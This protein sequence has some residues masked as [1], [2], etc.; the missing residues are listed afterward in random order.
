MDAEKTC[1]F[2]AELIKVDAIKCRYCHSDLTA[3]PK[4][5][6]LPHPG[7]DSP[8]LL[9]ASYPAY[10]ANRLA[11]STSAA[12]WLVTAIVLFLVAGFA[13]MYGFVWSDADQSL[14]EQCF[15]MMDPR[16]CPDSV[17]RPFP[18]GSVIFACLAVFAGLASLA[19]WIVAKGVRSGHVED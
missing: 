8:G 5:A 12:S 10:A 7:A 16:P 14:P 2:C 6:S 13:L 11:T 1:P 4:G 17:P 9:A 18:T 19:V 3:Q 15:D